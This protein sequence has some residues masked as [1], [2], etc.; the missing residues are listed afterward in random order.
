MRRR[1]QVRLF[2]VGGFKW[3]EGNMV[4]VECYDPLAGAWN[5]M[6]SMKLPRFAFA[7]AAMDGKLSTS[8]AQERTN[9][10][11]RCLRSKTQKVLRF[12]LRSER[13]PGKIKHVFCVGVINCNNR[14]F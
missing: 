4:S 12:V 14:K 9:C 13:N 7:G 1:Q 5:I 8:V 10:V 6:E 3:P 2:A 11:F